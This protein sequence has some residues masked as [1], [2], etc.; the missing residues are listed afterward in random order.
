MEYRQLGA[1]RRRRQPEWGS[2]PRYLSLDDRRAIGAEH[3]ATLARRGRTLRPV[4]SATRGRAPL[5]TTFWGRAWC[6]NLAAYAALANRL[7]RGRSYLRNSLVI[8]LE[9]GPGRVTALVSGS[10]VY[11]VQVR[12]APMDPGRWKHVVKACAGKIDSV[13]ELLAG[14]FDESVMAHVCRQDTGLF[15]S[16]GEIRYEC[17]CPDG[18]RGAWLCKH[19]AATLYGVGVRLDE[20]PE[21][22]FR[23]RR[24][25]HADL[26]ARAAAGL[27]D[28]PRSGSARRAIASDRLSAVFGIDLEDSAPKG[29][30]LVKS[31]PKGAQ[32]RRPRNESPRGARK[33]TIRRGRRRR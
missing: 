33:P 21:M 19:V 6:E 30:E 23:L 13:V 29:A 24:V 31:A 8:H 28:A 1:L 10:E 32:A 3:A 15:P 9:I 20:D 16:P 2:W 25:A 26:L 11:Q 7:G 5:A 12:I 4:V 27:A 22:L 14:R 18:S 17:T